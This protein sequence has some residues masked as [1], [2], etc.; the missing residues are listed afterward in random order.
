LGWEFLSRHLF[1]SFL[2]TITI[3]KTR[4]EKAQ[5]PKIG[6]PTY[7]V[8]PVLGLEVMGG[9]PVG[10]ENDDG[11]GPRDVEPDA[12][13]P[14]GQQEDENTG[15]SVELS[16]NALPGG[17]QCSANIINKRYTHKTSSFKTTGFKMSGFKTSKTSG[18]QNVRFTKRQVYKMSG[19]QNVRLQN[20]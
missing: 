3:F 10:V 8:G 6:K 18:L 14:G 20:E 17:P 12:A 19:L 11:V 5:Q 13:H 4:R 1:L 15:V 16:H 9:I 2:C 7:S